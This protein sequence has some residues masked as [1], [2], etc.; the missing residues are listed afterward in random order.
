[1]SREIEEIFIYQLFIDTINENNYIENSKF[2]PCYF[3][4]F[5]VE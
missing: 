5:N 1:M 4:Y 3:F 2:I